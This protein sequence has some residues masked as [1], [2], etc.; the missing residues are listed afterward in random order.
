MFSKHSGSIDKVLLHFHPW[1]E[2]KRHCS[3]SCQ[4]G[5]S[6]CLP[7]HDPIPPSGN[8]HQTVVTRSSSPTRP[9]EVVHQ[10]PQIDVLPN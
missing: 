6:R 5:A 1:S 2:E 9:A 10:A 8:A 7:D 4:G 3:V